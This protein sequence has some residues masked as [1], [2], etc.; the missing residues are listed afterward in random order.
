MILSYAHLSP[1]VPRVC[2]V[3]Q[4]RDVAAYLLYFGISFLMEWGCHSVEKREIMIET[5]AA[6]QA[7]DMLD[8]PGNVKNGIQHK[9]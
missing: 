8:I 4:L 2:I 1:N 6:V 3:Q 9:R 5:L 7:S